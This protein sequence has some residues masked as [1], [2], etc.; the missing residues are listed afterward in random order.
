MSDS[1]Y[2]QPDRVKISA[3]FLLHR[4]VLLCN[5]K[6]YGAGMPCGGRERCR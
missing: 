3:V 4:S 1:G 6:P 2:F 5:K